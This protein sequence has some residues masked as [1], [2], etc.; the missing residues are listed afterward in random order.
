MTEPRRRRRDNIL[1]LGLTGLA[2]ASISL[3]SYNI[4][5][6]ADCMS[7]FQRVITER[8]AEVQSYDVAV[9]ELI[10]SL[11]ALPPRDEVGEAMFRQAALERYAVFENAYTE[12]RAARAANPYPT[13]IC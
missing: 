13:E 3:S 12:L 4:N 7:Q 6:Q 9:F 11:F 8:G 1:A 5:R 10:Q 2:V